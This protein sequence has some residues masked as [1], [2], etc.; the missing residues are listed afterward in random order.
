MK[1]GAMMLLIVMA[2]NKDKGIEIGPHGYGELT[3]LHIPWVDVLS[4]PET[5]YEVLVYS[6]H[7][8][9]CLRLEGAVSNRAA[10][11]NE[12]P[13]YLVEATRELPFGAVDD[14][15]ECICETSRLKIPGYPLLIEIMSGCATTR[16]LGYSAI[17]DHWAKYD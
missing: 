7:C 6:P 17:A 13:L 3:Q 10:A 12:E 4:Q 14:L 15:T 1:K 9:Y 8:S 11:T 2:I 5:R 16:I